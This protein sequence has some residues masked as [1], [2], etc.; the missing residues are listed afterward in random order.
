MSS[1]TLTFAMQHT[2]DI[3]STKHIKQKQTQTLR[4]C[5]CTLSLLVSPRG[6]KNNIV[7][8]AAYFFS[9]RFDFL[10]SCP[11]LP[12]RPFLVHLSVCLFV[13]QFPSFPV[14][15]TILL[16]YRETIPRYDY[17]R[18]YM[19]DGGVFKFLTRSSESRVEEPEP[20]TTR[21]YS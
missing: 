4:D 10:L 2:L 7:N 5:L 19:R 1:R 3:D 6:I 17:F 15:S 8:F 16:I 20:A 14:P 13:C 18:L 12:P 9:I 11:R 21:A